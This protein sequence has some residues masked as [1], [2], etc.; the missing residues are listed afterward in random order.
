MRT[1]A[2]EQEKK[3]S[4]Q[5][6][7]AQVIAELQQVVDGLAESMSKPINIIRGPDGRAATLQ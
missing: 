4:E 2:V 3:A 7:I 6:E 5:S 1:E